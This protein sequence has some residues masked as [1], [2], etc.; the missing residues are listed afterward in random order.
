[1]SGEAALVVAA[2]G[3]QSNVL[4]QLLTIPHPP[5]SLSQ[6]AAAL[7]AAARLDFFYKLP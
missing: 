3:G 7:Y 4:R 2:R 6:Q 1:M 5:P